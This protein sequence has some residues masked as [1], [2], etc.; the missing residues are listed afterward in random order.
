MKFISPY[1][2]DYETF[3]LDNKLPNIMKNKYCILCVKHYLLETM[4]D[5]PVGI[6]QSR[7]FEKW[8]ML[9]YF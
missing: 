5:I 8:S 2:G 1:R 6:L 4:D 3:D 9:S 7:N